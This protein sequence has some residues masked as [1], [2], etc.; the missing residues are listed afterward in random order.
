MLPEDHWGNQRSDEE[1][2][3][4]ICTATN[5]TFSRE[6]LLGDNE[7]RF[8]RSTTAHCPIPLKEHKVQLNIARKKHQ[9]KTVQK[10]PDGLF[11]V[12][13]PG[14]VVQKNDQFTSVIHEP[15]KLEVTVRNSDIAKFRARDERKTKLS[16]YINRRGPKVYEKSTEAKMLSHKK[17]SHEFRRATAR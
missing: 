13:A 10:I 3:N 12:L 11:E 9:K 15:G 17:N 6:R 7:P 2:E 16:E 14:S 1:V 4:H 8:L 5:D